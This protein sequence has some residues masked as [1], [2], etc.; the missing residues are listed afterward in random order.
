MDFFSDLVNKAQDA[1]LSIGKGYAE[2]E[3]YGDDT[4]RQIALARERDDYA[5]LN[6]SG[7]YDRQ[8]ALMD[9]KKGNYV[10]WDSSKPFGGVAK[11]PGAIALL[12]LVALGVV[13]AFRKLA[14]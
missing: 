9:A 12:V 6:G 4:A 2:R 7:P 8:G 1:A 10:F 11:N 14:R 5:G 3:I 13:F